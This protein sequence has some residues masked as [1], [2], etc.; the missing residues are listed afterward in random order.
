MNPK[1][2]FLIKLWSDSLERDLGQQAAAELESMLRDPELMEQFADW[3]AERSPAEGAEPPATPDL[4]R[5]VRGAFNS[6]SWAFRHWQQLL[7][8]G[9]GLGALAVFVNALLP[10][11]PDVLVV[12][13]DDRPLRVDDGQALDQAQDEPLP[14]ATSRPTLG[15]PPGF[16][17]RSTRLEA[18]IDGKVELRWT[19][20]HDGEAEVRVVDH[21]GK[22]VRTVWKGHAE[23]GRYR[24]QWNGKDEDGRL[25]APGAYRLQALRSGHLLAEQRFDLSAAE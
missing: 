13:T 5:R 23:E 14:V 10:R 6:R 2:E 22:T 1:L 25:V 19:M 9:I 24:N 11:K 21:N 16:G 3:Q 12:S 15:P 8:V 7:A 20:A 18:K 4:D 17:Q